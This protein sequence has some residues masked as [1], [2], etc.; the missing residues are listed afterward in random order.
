MSILHEE[1]ED[2]EGDFVKPADCDK[3]PRS[4]KSLKGLPPY[5]AGVDAAPPDSL[6]VSSSSCRQLLVGRGGRG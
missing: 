1:A 3:L 2:G 6:A 5:P 4:G